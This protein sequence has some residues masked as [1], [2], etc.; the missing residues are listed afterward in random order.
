MVFSANKEF[1]CLESLP[2]VLF[3]DSRSELF[4]KDT[5]ADKCLDKS[6]L[7]LSCLQW[8]ASNF[9]RVSSVLQSYLPKQD[10]AIPAQRTSS[11]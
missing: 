2:A 3:Q 9:P 11:P 7:V 8:C 5:A 6:L 1:V 10:H 4:Q